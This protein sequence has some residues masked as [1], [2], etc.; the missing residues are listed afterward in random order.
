MYKHDSDAPARGIAAVNQVGG[1]HSAR[2]ES[3]MMTTDNAFKEY[4]DIVSVK[5]LQE[6]LHIGKNRAL[7][8]LRRNEISC[9]RI[10]YTFKIPKVNVIE[11]L[12]RN[13]IGN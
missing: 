2:K 6:M 8:L 4:P 12:N 9:I 13:A 5:Q 10:G 7:E 11:F 1:E 3:I